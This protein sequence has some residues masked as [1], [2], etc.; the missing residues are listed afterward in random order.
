MN[1]RRNNNKPVPIQFNTDELPDIECSKC[2][3]KIF[4]TASRIKKI[5][6]I[7][8]PNGQDSYISIPVSV[9]LACQEP[10][11]LKP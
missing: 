5:S 7:I 4:I 2:G 6:A 1:Q 3:G 8:S 11:P 9:C 10:L